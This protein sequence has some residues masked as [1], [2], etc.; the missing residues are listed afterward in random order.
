[1]ATR[2]GTELAGAGAST[3]TVAVREAEWKFS[4]WP[5]AGALRLGGGG[6]SAIRRDGGEGGGREERR[7][8]GER[9]KSG[10]RKGKKGFSLVCWQQVA[11]GEVGI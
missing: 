6:S 7:G 10:E 11:P 1:M 8:R 9:R 4:D 5:T 2:G 3:E